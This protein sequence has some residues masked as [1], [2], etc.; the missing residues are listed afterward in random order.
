MRESDVLYVES[1]SS[2]WRALKGYLSTSIFCM[3]LSKR[4]LSCKTRTL[5]LMRKMRT[6]WLRSCVIIILKEWSTFTA[7][8]ILQYFAGSVLSNTTLMM[9]ALLLIYMRSKEWGS[10]KNR[11]LWTIQT[12]HVSTSDNK[13]LNEWMHKL[14]NAIMYFYLKIFLQC[15]YKDLVTSLVI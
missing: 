8:T 1:L 2:S 7:R 3:K 9:N 10:S 12:K 4:T 6:L 15:Y 5:I 13:R 11:I 14:Y